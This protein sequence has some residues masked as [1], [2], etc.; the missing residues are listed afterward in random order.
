MTARID[1]RDIA[2]RALRLY[3]AEGPAAVLSKVAEKSA[4]RWRTAPAAVLE[5]TVPECPPADRVANHRDWLY[6]GQRH[7][8]LISVVIPSY[9]HAQFVG[10][11]IRSVAEQTYPDIELI[12]VD[13]GSSDGSAVA[14]EDALTSANRLSRTILIK[15]D[16]QGAHSAINRGVLNSHGEYV[17]ILNSDDFYAPERLERLYQCATQRGNEF[18]F[19]EVTHVN[20]EGV[21]LLGKVV[22]DYQEWLD[23]VERYPSLSF[24]LLR[25]NGTRSSSNFFFS[26]RLVERIGLFRGFRL[27]HDW[28][29]ALRAMRDSE[30][31]FVRENLLSYR[32]HG[33]G[34]LLGARDVDEAVTEY[35]TVLADYFRS[36]RGRHVPNQFAPSP[37]NWPGF[38]GQFVRG[39]AYLI[40]RNGVFPAL[41]ELWEAVE[42]EPAPARDHHPLT[43]PPSLIELVGSTSS[44]H[45][46]ET[47]EEFFQHFISLGRLERTHNVLDVGCGS[48]RMAVRLARYLAP[49]AKY[50]GFDVVPSAVAWC[51]SEIS[52]RY[53]NFDFYVA[54]VRND[55]YNPECET[56]AAR[57]Q[58]PHDDFAFDFVFLTSVFTHMLPADMERYVAEISRVLKPGGRC[59]ATFFL[60]NSVSL[61]HVKAGDST[62]DFAHD[63][64]VYRTISED[65]PEYAVCYDEEFIRGLFARYELA[66][67]N[68]PY[69]GSWCGR[70]GHTSYQ[71]L[72]VAVRQ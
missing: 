39:E 33:S 4:H 15:Q 37:L 38:F 68:A 5:S 28:D 45:Y 18:A 3:H 41:H 40:S 43:P 8:G 44:S 20:S 57:Y 7:P 27:V 58:F 54:D 56:T 12:V 9:N 19:T 36:V 66:I 48:G 52:S 59:L 30:P 6:S 16:N 53:P 63:H 60:G 25:T 21:A 17:C 32:I 71:D 10:E 11:A 13:D 14:I 67:E 29:F 46:H 64:G 23:G 31:A 24:S 51:S 35:R 72:V 22:G 2:T 61:A 47:G 26:A 55:F 1:V 42:R 65:S 69:F 50:R 70:L 62:L 49:S 34:T